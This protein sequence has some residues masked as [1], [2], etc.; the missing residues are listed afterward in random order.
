MEVSRLS[1]GQ[2]RAAAGAYAIATA[3]LDLSRICDLR[4]NLQCRIFNQMSEARDHTHILR[5]TM[6]GS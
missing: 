4:H 3:K 1:K 6:S 5:E 2:I